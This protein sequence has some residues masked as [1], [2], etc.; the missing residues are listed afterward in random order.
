[1]THWRDG[2]KVL[3][4]HFLEPLSLL[5]AGYLELDKSTGP[6]GQYYCLMLGRARGGRLATRLT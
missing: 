1:M 5:F 4:W 6:Y 3:L 2:G